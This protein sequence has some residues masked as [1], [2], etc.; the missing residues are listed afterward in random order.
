VRVFLEPLFVAVEFR[1]RGTGTVGNERE[2]GAL[3]IEAEV[4]HASLLSHD[5]VDAQLL[6]DGFEHIEVAVGPGAD[7]APITPGANDLFRRTTP[8]DALARL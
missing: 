6:P 4:A 1:G 5:G 7:Q 3:D 8:Q 2:Q